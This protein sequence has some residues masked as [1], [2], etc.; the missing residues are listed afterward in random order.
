LHVSAG[1]DQWR[2]ASAACWCT[3]FLLCRVVYLLRLVPAWID[4]RDCSDGRGLALPCLPE[5][6]YSVRMKPAFRTLIALLLCLLLP[7][8]AG[9]TL[10]RSTAMVLRGGMH[11]ATVTA[12]RA[13]DELQ[14]AASP[15]ALHAGHDTQAMHA[16]HRH[17][18]DQPLQHHAP[19]HGGH[20]LQPDHAP[21]ANII[22]SAH[23]K[24]HAKTGCVDC[25]KCCLLAASA[26]PPA[27]PPSLAPVA[28]R[29]SFIAQHAPETAFFT[30]GPERPPRPP[31][32]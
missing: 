15:Q 21:S 12:P 14:H 31:I 17:H 19:V 2:L 32:A 6:R 26:P 28:A 10:A 18:G 30:D 13:V 23:H 11:P 25:A 7:L 5:G 3:A 4:G 22:L 29:V 20:D 1:C 16:M 27:R 8:Q 9:A 24:T